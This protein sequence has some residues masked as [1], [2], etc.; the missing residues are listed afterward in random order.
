[1]KI[2]FI[3]V[4]F[5]KKQIQKKKINLNEHFFEELKKRKKLNYTKHSSG[6]EMWRF[7]MKD[8][9]SL[10]TEFFIKDIYTYLEFKPNLNKISKY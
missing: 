5:L 3:K 6:L 9:F 10:A 8:F 2:T 7:K 1:M 4:F